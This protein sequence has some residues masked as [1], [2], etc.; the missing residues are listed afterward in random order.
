[1]HSSI[2]DTFFYRY[3]SDG[4]WHRTADFDRNTTTATAARYREPDMLPRGQI[5]VYTGRSWPDGPHVYGH[6]EDVAAYRRWEAAPRIAAQSALCEA[7]FPAETR[8]IAEGTSR[9]DVVALA[10]QSGHADEVVCGR[11]ETTRAAYLDVVR[12]APALAA[13]LR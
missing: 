7:G 4:D 10:L 5:A 11:G 6:P 12:R 8:V 13:A 2:G 1:M 9:G 3:H